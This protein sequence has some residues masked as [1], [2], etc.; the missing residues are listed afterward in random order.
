MTNECCDDT[1]NPLHKHV[2]LSTGTQTAHTVSFIY[3]F[4]YSE[5]ANF[6]LFAHPKGT[7]PDKT[8][9]HRKRYTFGKSKKK[10]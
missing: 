2:R 3:P 1:I 4:G 5:M 8:V 9:R 6:S 10:L 7:G